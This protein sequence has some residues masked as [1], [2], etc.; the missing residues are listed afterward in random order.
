[1][2]RDLAQGFGGVVA[3]CVNLA[4]ACAACINH[5]GRLIAA[6]GQ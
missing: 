3:A 2:H 5:G 6:S 4:K 1:M